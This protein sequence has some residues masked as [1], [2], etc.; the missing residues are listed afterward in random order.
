MKQILLFTLCNICFVAM[1]QKPVL[2]KTWETDSIMAVPES[3]LP[4]NG[5]LY[6]SLIDGG[7]WEADGKGAIAKLDASGKNYQPDWVTGLNAPKGMGLA[8]NR[9]Y[10]AD[11]GD[12]VVIDIANAAIE[13]KISIDS[14]TGLNDITV[15]ADGIVYASDSRSGKIWRIENDSARLYLENIKGLN[16]LKAVGD[17]LFIGAGKSFVKADKQKKLTQ[18]AEVAQGIDGIEPAGNGDFILTAW[19]GYIWYVSA[20]G[21]VETL[22]ETHQ[23]KINSADIGYDPVKK[24]VYVP[25]F[26]AKTV[27]AYQLK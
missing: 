25:T 21:R 10:V 7:P 9:L 26:F 24:I 12:I 20:D 3:V 19:G 27:A 4:D 18:I 16:G 5:T 1:A 15:S 11:M 8:G 14:A 17:E 13:K 6:I 22:L 23:Q 2:Q